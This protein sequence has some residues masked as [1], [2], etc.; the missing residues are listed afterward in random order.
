VRSEHVVSVGGRRGPG[1][2][3]SCT[4]FP[5]TPYSWSNIEPRSWALGGRPVP[6]LRGYHPDTIVDGRPMTPRR[7]D[8]RAGAA[9][10]DRRER[11]VFVGH[12]WG[13][14]IAYV[15]ATLAP[16]R[17]RG[18][19]TFAIPHPSLLPRHAPSL[20]RHRQSCRED[21]WAKR[22]RPAARLC[23]LDELSD[24]LGAETGLARR[25]ESLGRVKEALSSRPRSTA[26]STTTAIFA[27]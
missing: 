15:A 25:D 9:R 21:P 22:N 27:G 10:A 17:F 6:W 8:T 3:C 23:L 18:L 4:R 14:M 2:W 7:S 5:D 24:R 12:D 13:A 16:E 11:A 1:Q 19:G 26:R 20:W